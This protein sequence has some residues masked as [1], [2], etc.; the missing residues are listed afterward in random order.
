LS[1]R[2]KIEGSVGE[3]LYKICTY[4]FELKTSDPVDDPKVVDYNAVVV[5]FQC[6]PY[7]KMNGMDY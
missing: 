7:I 3:Q 1:R 2:H 6:D 4:R 5:T